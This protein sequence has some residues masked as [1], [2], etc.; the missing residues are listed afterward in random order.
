MGYKHLF[1]PVAADEYVNAYDWYA[2][3]SHVAADGLLIAIEETIQLICEN[4]TRYRNTYKKLREVSLKKYPY[5][6]VY[7]T[8]EGNKL[9]IITSVY[10]HRRN[11][12][13]KYRK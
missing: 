11:P 3:R 8:D 13:K 6:I 12:A 10:H 5:S 2:E 7:Y 4:P 9:I 1:D